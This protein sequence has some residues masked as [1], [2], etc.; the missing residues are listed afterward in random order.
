MGYDGLARLILA[1][2]G[3]RAPLSGVQ[4]LRQ[5]ALDGDV[6]A[7]V[8][9]CRVLAWEL[10]HDPGAAGLVSAAS[11]DALVQAQ[12]VP[13]VLRLHALGYEPAGAIVA[14][15]PGR[16]ELAQAFD[17]DA[18]MVALRRLVL[19]HAVMA[20]EALRSF[21]LAGFVRVY[22][23]MGADVPAAAKQA[24]LRHALSR[25][26]VVAGT[27]ADTGFEF[28]R[29]FLLARPSG[30]ALMT[31]I[32]HE[33]G[34]HLLESQR[35]YLGEGALV[36]PAPQPAAE[37][38]A[39]ASAAQAG[40]GTTTVYAPDGEATW[41]D[42]G[43]CSQL[44]HGG[45]E[46][47]PALEA[48]E[49]VRVAVRVGDPGALARALAAA[50][51]TAAAVAAAGGAAPT[52]ATE[53]APPVALGDAGLAELGRSCC[54]VRQHA[55]EGEG[56]GAAGTHMGASPEQ[57][58]ACLSELHAAGVPLG[59]PVTEYGDS[60]LTDAAAR[61][62]EL[63]TALLATGVPVDAAAADGTTPLAVAAAD[64]DVKTATIL[65]D[66]GAAA[67]ARD[68]DGRTPL[69]AAAAAAAAVGVGAGAGAAELC[70]LLLARG[71]D[72]DAR[73]SRGATP[74]LEASSAGA[75]TTLCSGGADVDAP[76]ASGMRPLIAAAIAGRLEVV[77]AL[78]AAG[79][80]PEA[81]TE[82]GRVALH[83]AV[84]A[85]GDA[86]A[87][88]IVAALLDA[89]AQVDEEAG[90]GMTALM[91]AALN[92]R[93]ALVSALLARGADAARRTVSGNTAL[94]MAS[95]G[96]AELDRDLSTIDRMR[97]CIRVLVAGGAEVDATNDAGETALIW[98]ARGFHTGPVQT[99]LELGADPNARS[100]AGLTPLGQ[101]RAAGHEQ[102]AADLVAAGAR[103]PEAGP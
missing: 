1:G 73:C 68:C 62:G 55:E 80:D 59:G 48:G 100:T 21:V 26:R 6:D 98:A 102:M 7:A 50:A 40:A 12:D 46:S 65:L 14:G 79:A 76:D 10:G 72:V 49:L 52:A 44:A 82:L 42:L 4:T 8:T 84:L 15:L 5:A 25:T 35:A 58:L 3:R 64:V 37:A 81:A 94:I 74:L 19:R 57:L 99:L 9:L 78:L 70:G 77:Q 101:A 56:E 67:G 92:H 13:P 103:E 91:V 97:E 90:D 47:L 31:A 69:H 93:T 60:L 17:A 86:Q 83:G 43:I 2:P 89:G 39:E 29:D 22:A 18:E 53:A 96:R 41:R 16:Y 66:A 28:G 88:A 51:A 71:A 24:T 38:A 85:P 20:D 63:V 61:A 36:D 75:V 23:T 27:A 87:Q 54:I 32:A 11:R 34:H 95:D 30:T 45:E 33:L